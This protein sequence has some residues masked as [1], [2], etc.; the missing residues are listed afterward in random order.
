MQKSM[1]IF[2]FFV[3]LWENP[4]VSF[5]PLAALGQAWPLSPDSS[6]GTCPPSEEIAIT[7]AQS[8]Q[9]PFRYFWSHWVPWRSLGTV[10]EWG[11]REPVPVCQG[12]VVQWWLLHLGI[13]KGPESSHPNTH[14][15]TG[16]GST[17][18]RFS[19]SGKQRREILVKAQGWHLTAAAITF[20][21]QPGLFIPYKGRAAASPKAQRAASASQLLPASYDLDLILNHYYK[22]LFQRGSQPVRLPARCRA[23]QSTPGSVGFV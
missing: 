10:V 7:V 6:P 15:C 3:V 8:T 5:W 12:D 21:S 9:E 16:C 11:V 4:F 2:R 18:L 1:Q 19:E 17:A 22:I 14:L 13:L 20:I 23:L